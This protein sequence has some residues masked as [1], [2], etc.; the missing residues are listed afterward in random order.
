MYRVKEDGRICGVLNDFDLSSCLSELEDD[1]SST[2][3]QRTGTPPFMAID[4]LVDAGQSA[5]KHLYRHDLESFFYVMAVFT[6][7]YTLQGPKHSK[8]RVEPRSD[9]Q[10]LPF[11]NW[12][13]SEDFGTLRRLKREFILDGKDETRDKKIP[14]SAYVSPSFQ[15]LVPWLHSIRSMFRL[16]FLARSTHRAEEDAWE[17]RASNARERAKTERTARRKNLLP[18]PTFD[19]ATLGNKVSYNLFM[20]EAADMTFY[21]PIDITYE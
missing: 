11:E 17:T 1:V 9:M 16:A 8:P 21:K 3:L 12:F 10:P 15:G 14:M 13:Q 4:L 7:R 6:S 2:S 20:A 18:R 19:D 5:P